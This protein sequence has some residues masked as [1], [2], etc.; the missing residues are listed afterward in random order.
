MEPAP[1][2]TPVGRSNTHETH[3]AKHRPEFVCFG[4]L[5]ADW[6]VF[7]LANELLIVGIFTV[8]F[9]V[10]SGTNQK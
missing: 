9:F 6:K 2:Q 10:D 7:E 1:D 4:C 5:M 3:C 8:I